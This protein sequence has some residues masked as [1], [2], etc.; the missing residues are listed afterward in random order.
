MRRGNGPGR[1]AG[2]GARGTANAAAVTQAQREG[3]STTAGA[4]GGPRPHTNRQ[5]HRGGGL[6]QRA[7]G[8]AGGR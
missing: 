1:P 6:V 7:L 2:Y 4:A 8:R 5:T 3:G